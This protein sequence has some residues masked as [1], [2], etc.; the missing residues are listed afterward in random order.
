MSE[1]SQNFVD[2]IIQRVQNHKGDAAALKRADNPN[3]EYQAWE[4]L[5]RFNVQ[6]DQEN[7][8]LPF[9]TIAADIAR[10]KPSSNGKTQVG[11]A[12]ARCYEDGNES[13]QARAK[14]RRLLACETTVEVCRI[15]RPLLSL[16]AAKGNI[17][18]DY[19]TLLDQLLW[20]SHEDSR[21]RTKA[22]WAQSFYGKV[23]VES[24]GGADE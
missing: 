17:N 20:F 3:T 11:Q 15:L 9:S 5:A 6:L 18:L 16:I 12:I 24:K 22:R 8:R 14:L 1:Y 4:I 21:L 10:V 13:S 23:G 2:Y 7:Q 19:A